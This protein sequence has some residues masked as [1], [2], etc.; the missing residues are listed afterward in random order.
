MINPLS[1]PVYLAV[2]RPDE[3]SRL[4]DKLVLDGLNVVSF[5]SA[6]EL[7]QTFHQ[8][9][10]RL[11]VCDRRFGDGFD[12]LR[13]TAEIRKKYPLPYIYVVVLSVLNSI[14]DVREALAAGVDDYIIKPH[15]PLQVRSRILVG[16]RWLHYIDS[17][18]QPQPASRTEAQP[19]QRR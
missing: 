15:H 8:K 10:A 3:L 18:T 16:Q 5:K 13:L 12:A 6:L 7:W 14:K 17:I 19:V 9:P 2:R 11:I 1:G 4:E